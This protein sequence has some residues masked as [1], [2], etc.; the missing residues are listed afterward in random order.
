MRSCDILYIHST[1]NPNDDG[2]NKYATIPMGII[3]I[4]NRIISNG[5]SVIGINLALEKR[6][7]YQYDIQKTLST[8]NYKILM[9]DLHWYE[10]SYGA[11]EIA[12]KSK[13]VKPDIPVI[14]GGYT[15][16]IFSKEIMENFNCIDY[17]ITGDS[18]DPACMLVDCI[19]NKSHNIYDVPNLLFRKDGMIIESTKTWVATDLDQ[20]NF[21]DIGFFEHCD[22]IP[23][24]SIDGKFKSFSSF[25][26]CIARGCKFNCSYCCGANENMFA[27]FRRCNILTR[28]A[29]KVADDFMKIYNS[30]IERVS[31]SHDLQMFGKKYYKDVFSKIRNNSIRKGLYLECFQL[32]TKD[33]IDEIAKTFD[34]SMVNIVISPISGNELLRKENGKLFSNDEL[35]DTIEYIKSK[36]MIITLYYTVNIVGESKEQF[37]DTYFQM[38][39]LNTVLGIEKKSIL[40]QRVVLDP[41]AGMRKNSN[42]NAQYNSFMDYYKYCQS[43]NSKYELTGFSDNAALSTDTK[44][45]YY[46]SI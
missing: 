6:I 23:I 17:I 40:Y 4:L 21:T 8:Y 29:E 22:Q 12:K 19:I 31:P 38:K 15:S 5:Y 25:W 41:L 3:G 34:P 37:F 26:L 24:M 10:H 1:K 2:N 27:L 11:I 30:G 18:D 45:D 16:T 14:I 36:Q 20:I 28:S 43:N 39:Y 35:Y 46:A 44:L 13:K 7:N 32:P 42:I 9:T 33:Y